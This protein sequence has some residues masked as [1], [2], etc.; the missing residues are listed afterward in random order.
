MISQSYCS[1]IA[2]I[3]IFDSFFDFTKFLQVKKNSQVCIMWFHEIFSKFAFKIFGKMGERFHEILAGQ[4]K[5]A[6]NSL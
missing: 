6:L 4:Q 2:R 5:R 3:W 1:K